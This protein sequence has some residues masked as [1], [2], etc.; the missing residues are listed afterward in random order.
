M[1]S[2]EI[3]FFVN[4]F[5]VSGEQTKKTYKTQQRQR[6]KE[7]TLSSEGISGADSDRTNCKLNLIK[8]IATLDREIEYVE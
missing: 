2:T 1:F 4:C 8:L 6:K 3:H 5:I 7:K